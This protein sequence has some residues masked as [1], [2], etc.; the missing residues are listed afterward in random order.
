MLKKISIGIL[1]VIA[2]PFIAALFIK[3]HYEVERSVV[4]NKPVSK[5]FSYV[6]L[7]QNQNNYATWGML[8]PNIKRSYSGVDGTVG[9]VSKWESDNPDVGVG[10]QEITSITPNKRIE[11]ELRFIKPFVATS[12]AYMTTSQS[13]D[14]STKVSWG[15]KGHLDYPMNIMFLFI[16]FET[17]I[18]N[19]L[20]Q[21]LNNLKENLDKR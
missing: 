2:I 7:L 1:I 21:G 8:D 5:V 15:F 16:D 11:F 17:Q 10:E 6:K 4:I 19:D 3:T 12:P 14:N 13:G 9:F 18:G 20:Q